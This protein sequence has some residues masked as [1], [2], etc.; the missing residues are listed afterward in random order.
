MDIDDYAE[1]NRAAWNQV[2][3]IHRRQRKN[4]LRLEVQAPGFST[5]DETERGIY[6]TLPVRGATV[7]QICCNN[8]R[9]LISLLKY[10]AASGVGFDIAEE[11]VAE[12][13]ELAR[14]AGVDGRFVRTNAYDIG[15]EHDGRFDLVF[16][17]IGALCWFDDMP[18]FFAVAARLLRP[19]GHLFVYESHP[20]L[21][22]LALPNEGPFDPERPMNAVY[23]YFKKEPFVDN[24]G[25]DYVGGTAYEAKT[26]YAF[27]HT[28]GAVI[29]AVLDNGLA[30]RHFREYPHDISNEFK[31]LEAHR[32]L[33]LCYTLVAQ[34][35]PEDRGQG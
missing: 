35:E 27:P 1:R 10:G 23:S 6:R 28:V 25:L 13:A 31:Y 21:D 11:F 17:T 15:A 32:M 33:P 14:L 16:T 24:D 29:G 3:P 2:A 30:L 18:R 8:G 34:K 26:T 7:A 22:L 20:Y 19:G 5:F 12:A 9:E 4:D